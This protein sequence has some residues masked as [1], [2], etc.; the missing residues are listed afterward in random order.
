MDLSTIL[1]SDIKY[2]LP[3]L[4]EVVATQ[5]LDVLKTKI[6]TKQPFFL[7]DTFRGLPYRAMGFLPVRTAFWWAQHNTPTNF[8]LF[9]KAF[10]ISGIQAAIDI[11]IDYFKIRHINRIQTPHSLSQVAKVATFHSMRNFMFCYSLLYTRYFINKYKTPNI[12][13][14]Y[15]HI[16]SMMSGCLLGSAVS[17]PLDVLKTRFT[18]DPKTTLRFSMRGLFPRM[19]IT[20]FGIGIGQVVLLN[21][22][23]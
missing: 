21:L 14:Y 10:F 16:G 18:C 3:S 20:T 7:R 8:N 4:V 11:P 13:P 23:L 12:H 17:Q 6:Q 2:V 5:P 19:M 22:N 9:Q 15:Y 1:K